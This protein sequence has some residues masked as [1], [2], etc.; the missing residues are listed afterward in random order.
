[1]GDLLYEM[2]DSCLGIVDAAGVVSVC[3]Y[4]KVDVVF[5]LVFNNDLCDAVV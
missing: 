3:E 2:F 5:L 4:D 1:M